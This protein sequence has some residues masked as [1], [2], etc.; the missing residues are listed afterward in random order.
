M[1]W[2]IFNILHKRKNCK[3][4]ILSLAENSQGCQKIRHQ[5]RKKRVTLQPQII[6]HL[7]LGFKTGLLHTKIGRKCRRFI[8]N[9]DHIKNTPTPQDLGVQSVRQLQLNQACLS[10]HRH[11]ELIERPRREA[12]ARTTFTTSYFSSVTSV[13]KAI[14]SSWRGS[15]TSE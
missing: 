12:F 9:L 14:R 2:V 8:N 13:S 15:K 7:H 3:T 1:E 5:W 6:I 11:L 10:K 4:L